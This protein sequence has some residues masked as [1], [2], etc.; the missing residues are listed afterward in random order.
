MAYKHLTLAK[1]VM[2]SI[3]LPEYSHYNAL[4][5]VFFFVYPRIRSTLKQSWV[6]VLL[7]CVP[8]GLIL[9]AYSSPSTTILV[10]GILGVIPLLGIGD[11]VLDAMTSRIGTIYG[12]LLYVSTRQVSP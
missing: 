4:L 8:I 5:L 11:K 2:F 12:I 6:N 7:P 3:L 10:L 9:Q 1:F